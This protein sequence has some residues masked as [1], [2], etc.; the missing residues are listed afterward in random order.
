[1]KFLIDAQLPRRTK[2]YLQDAG[3]DA[4]HTL[5]LPNQNYTTDTEIIEIAEAESRVIITKDAD[6][7]DNLI[8]TGKPSRLLLFSMGNMTNK[9]LEALFVP[10]IPK[11]IDAFETSSFVEL[12]RTSMLIHF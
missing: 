8:M 12:N 11:I 9:E 4:L 3:H 7:V 1:M 6:F 2:Y 10:L 5:D